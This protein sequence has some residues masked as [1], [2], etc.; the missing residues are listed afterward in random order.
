MATQSYSPDAAWGYSQSFSPVS[1]RY[2]RFDST[3]SNSNPGMAEIIFYAVPEASSALLAGL[4]G[5][6]TVSRRRRH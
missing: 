6:L 3:A 5:L 2:V 4:A 1:A